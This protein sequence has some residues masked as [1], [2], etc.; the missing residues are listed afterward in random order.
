MLC[1]DDVQAYAYEYLENNFKVRE[2]NTTS[3]KTKFSE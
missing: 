3:S 2:L 1:S